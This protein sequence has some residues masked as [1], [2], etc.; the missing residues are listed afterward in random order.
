MK[1][2]HLI[3]VLGCLLSIGSINFFNAISTLATPSASQIYDPNAN[4]KQDI[5]RALAKAKTS[6]KRVL[7]DFGADW[8]KDCVVL[9]QLFEEPEIKTLLDKYFVVVRIDVGQWDKNLDI[10]SQYGNPIESGIPAV[11]VVDANEKLIA[12]TRQGELANARTAS[13]ETILEF[14]KKWSGR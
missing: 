2:I 10:S 11:V 12:S 7:I 9:A 8:C 4:P 3:V 6:K 13:K 5:K 1:S 14:L